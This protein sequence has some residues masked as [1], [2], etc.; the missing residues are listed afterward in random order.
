MGSCTLDVQFRNPLGTLAGYLHGRSCGD[1]L[2]LQ[3]RSVESYSSDAGNNGRGRLW[4]I[5]VL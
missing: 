4:D 5:H 1:Q 3:F 2:A